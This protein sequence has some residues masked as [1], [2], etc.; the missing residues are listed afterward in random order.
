M[1]LLKQGQETA[2]WLSVKVIGDLEEQ[3]LG[4]VWGGMGQ[5]HVRNGF[6]R[7]WTGESGEY[8]TP[9]KDVCC[10]GAAES[11]LFMCCKMQEMTVSL[12]ADG[13]KS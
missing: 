12:C 5:K 4:F 11:C 9:L 10:K 2:F 7:K 6:K 8:K 13:T 3:I 1:R